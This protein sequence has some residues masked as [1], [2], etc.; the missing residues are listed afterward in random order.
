MAP[1]SATRRH[2]ANPHRLV[3]ALSHRLVAALPHRE[4]ASSSV[5]AARSR[6]GASSGRRRLTGPQGYEVPSPLRTEF[7]GDCPGLLSAITDSMVTLEED[8]PGYT[9][10]MSTSIAEASSSSG[11][12]SASRAVHAD[13]ASTSRAPRD[14]ASTSR[15]ASSKTVVLDDDEDDENLYNFDRERQRRGVG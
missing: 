12:A 3:V 13:V 15:A 9:N 5:A 2:A 8:M 6:R 10:A 11:R 1:S 14:V 4:A 7:D